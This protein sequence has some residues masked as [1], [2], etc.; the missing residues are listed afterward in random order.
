MMYWVLVIRLQEKALQSTGAQSKRRSRYS[1]SNRAYSRTQTVRN[2]RTHNLPLY[3][4]RASIR[5]NDLDTLVYIGDLSPWQHRT[6]RSSCQEVSTTTIHRPLTLDQRHAEFPMCT[7]QEGTPLKPVFLCDTQNIDG[8]MFDVPLV[9]VPQ[10][11][12]LPHT[13]HPARRFVLMSEEAR[14]ASHHATEVSVREHRNTLRHRFEDLAVYA[15]QF[16]LKTG[17]LVSDSRVPELTKMMWALQD[18]PAIGYDQ[19]L[20]A[21]NAAISRL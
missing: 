6:A 4:K 11:P 13:H 10:H 1:Y 20:V 17:D 21:A 14:R 9:G 16:P 7:S 2:T 3:L 8:T 12:P 19:L 5:T 15:H 18:A